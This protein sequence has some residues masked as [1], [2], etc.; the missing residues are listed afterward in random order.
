MRAE[1][2]L[3]NSRNWDFTKIANNIERRRE[4]VKKKASI[5]MPLLCSDKN[6]N[7][8]NIYRKYSGDVFL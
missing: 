1:I 4:R 8:T 3:H 6:I 7:Q 5:R 2:L